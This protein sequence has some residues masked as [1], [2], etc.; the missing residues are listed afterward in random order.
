MK[1]YPGDIVIVPSGQCGTVWWTD[2]SQCNV[3]LRNF[4]MWSGELKWCH[5]AD[6]TEQAN[7]LTDVPRFNPF[8]EKMGK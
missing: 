5:L 6:E 7:A 4:D 8:F 1:I 3:I 2:G